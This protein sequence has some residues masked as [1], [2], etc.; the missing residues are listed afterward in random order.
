MRDL[1]DPV[2]P[3]PVTRNVLRDLG[4]RGVK[5]RERQDALSRAE[6]AGRNAAAV[7]SGLPNPSKEDVE[8]FGV[9]IRRI[10][11]D[12]STMP[13]LDSLL[14][15]EGTQRGDSR[16]FAESIH[17]AEQKERRSGKAPGRGTR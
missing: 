16:R 2:G 7:G 9:Q 12:V 10:E 6:Q 17:S 3:V 5:D 15:S 4:L 1:G 11:G 13:D 8:R 14:R